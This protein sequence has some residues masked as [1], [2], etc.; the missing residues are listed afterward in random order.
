MA[1]EKQIAANRSN[2]KRSTGPKTAVG[3]I[4]SSSNALRHGL[5]RPIPKDTLTLAKIEALAGALTARQNGEHQHAVTFACSQ[6][7][8]NRV[9]EL[10]AG[11]VAG[12]L[13][14]RTLR[15]L[16]SLERYEL[17]ARAKSRRAKRLFT[18]QQS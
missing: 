6:L 16:I 10:R 9:R 18:K 3:K 14:S 7:E 5:S 13:D 4:R 1:T 15:K 2:A 8:L 17:A 11:I 12:S